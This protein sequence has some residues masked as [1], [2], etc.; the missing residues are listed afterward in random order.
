MSQSTAASD[1][2]PYLPSQ[3]SYLPG[4]CPPLPI[5]HT[6]PTST[7]I[8]R[9]PFLLLSMFSPLPSGPLPPRASQPPLVCNFRTQPQ[10]ERKQH[11]R[12]C[13]QP[14]SALCLQSPSS[15]MQSSLSSTSIIIINTINHELHS[16]T[17]PCQGPYL[18]GFTPTPEAPRLCFGLRRLDHAVGNTHNLIETV[19]YIINMTGEEGWGWP[20]GMLSWGRGWTACMQ[21]A[22]PTA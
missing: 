8:N 20:G 2:P 3:G 21:L 22:T 16:H 18:P 12:C 6:T 17:F 4:S 15:A 14:T 7:P 5:P 9:V 1:P 11:A 13:P 19:T 10:H